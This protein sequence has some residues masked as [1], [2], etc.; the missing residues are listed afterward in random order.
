MYSDITGPAY[1]IET[2]RIRA[3]SALLNGDTSGGA[4]GK[5]GESRSVDGHIDGARSSTKNDGRCLKRLEKRIRIAVDGGSGVDAD[6]PV[7]AGVC[8]DVRVEDVDFGRGV[9]KYLIAG[10]GGVLEIDCI[11][12]DVDCPT[13]VNVI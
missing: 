5:V 11:S 12:V 9:D 8:Q 1:E 4:H 13:G 6:N 10:D 2:L 7:Y 3:I